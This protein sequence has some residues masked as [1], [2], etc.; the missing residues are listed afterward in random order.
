MTRALLIAAV[1][2]LTAAP[3]LAATNVTLKT[4]VLD[5]D[6]MV[7]L[8]DLFDGTGAAGKV[9]VAAK[10]GTSTVLD[11]GAVQ[12]LA[13]RNGLAWANAE[14]IRRIVVRGGAPAPAAARGNVEVLTYARSL[15]AGEIVQP[16]DLV[17]GKA[18]A[19]PSDAPND[20][21]TI[22]GLA[23]K[24]PLRAGAAVSSRDVSAPQVIK[25]GEL[26]TVLYEY[27]GISLSLQGKAMTA[28]SQGES[29]S[30]QNTSSKKM[31]QA[32]ASGPGQ[33][34][35]GPAADQIRGGRRTQVALR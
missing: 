33:A 31:I 14:G 18:A 1:A 29:L 28:A 19:A 11:A 6:G 26:I 32:V 5:D 21:E 34:M 15:S 22:I 25:A 8:S 30:V 20:A 10:P 12:G 23:A 2:W 27:D 16:Q 24:R 9:Q 7:T 13:R 35:V 4:E 3:A 17:W